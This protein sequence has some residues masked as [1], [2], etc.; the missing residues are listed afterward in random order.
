MSEQIK[1]LE[2]AR[3]T[4]ANQLKQYLGEAEKGTVGDRTISWKTINK[5]S[6]DTKRLKITSKVSSGMGVDLKKI[7]GSLKESGSYTGALV[8]LF[9]IW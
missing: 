8:Y 6:L 3:N 9:S 1:E 4:M 7:A 2:N 5:K